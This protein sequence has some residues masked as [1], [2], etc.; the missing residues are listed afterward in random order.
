LRDLQTHTDTQL[1]ALG[2][3]L[4][5]EVDQVKKKVGVEL[6]AEV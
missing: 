4:R 3:T 5:V 6:K 2:E 1:A